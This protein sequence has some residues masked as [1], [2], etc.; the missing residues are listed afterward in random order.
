MFELD[1]IDKKILTIL[2]QHGRISI[3][4][5]AERI[6]LSASPCTDRVKRLEKESVITGYQARV[7]PAALG[8][9]LLVFVEITLSSKSDEVFE[10][11]RKELLHVNEVMECHLVSGSFDY[12][13]KARLRGM[14]EYRNLL[15]AILK[16]LPVAAQSHSY[17]VMEELK[18]SLVIDLNR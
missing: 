14:S 8:K 11:V 18:E 1:R 6:G 13:V 5:L 16:K 7:S 2:Q 4:E 3:T 17:V 9:P 15:G 12:L 10:K